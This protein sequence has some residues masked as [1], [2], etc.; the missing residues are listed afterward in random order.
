MRGADELLLPRHSS[1]LRLTVAPHFHNAALCVWIE[2]PP[3]KHF[4]GMTRLL[5]RYSNRH[6]LAKWLRA[7]ADKLE[8]S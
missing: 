7:T 3:T 4:N 8:N 1:G 5:C 2:F 6:R